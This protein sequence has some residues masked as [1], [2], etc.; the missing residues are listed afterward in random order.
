MY[1]PLHALHAAQ[2]IYVFAWR[3][4][5]SGTVL[6]EL[7]IK[8]IILLENASVKIHGIVTDGAAINRKFWSEIGISGKKSELKSWFIHVLDKSRK[9]CVFSDTPH[10]VKTIRNRLYAHNLKVR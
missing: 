2:P 4:P 7:I 3:G 5:T 9:I 8:A 1:Q 6:A 10:I